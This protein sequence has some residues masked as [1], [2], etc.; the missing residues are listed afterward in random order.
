MLIE[1][2]NSKCVQDHISTSRNKLDFKKLIK[3][4]QIKTPKFEVIY[5]KSDLNNLDIY[6][7]CVV[8][9]IDGFSSNGVEVVKDKKRLQKAIN[10]VFVQNS[11]KSVLYGDQSEG[12]IIEEYIDGK[13]YSVDIIWNNS[14]A[15]DTIICSRI[16]NDLVHCPDYLYFI[17]P[18]IDKD[19]ELLLIENAIN[20][21]KAYNIIHGSTHTE[22][23]VKNN[24]AYVIDNA[25]R[26]GG[27][28]IIYYMFDKFYKTNVLENFCKSMCEIKS[29]K[30]V[31]KNTNG[32]EYPFL[33][34][35]TNRKKGKFLKLDFDFSHPNLTITEIIKPTKRGDKI[36]DPKMMIIYMFYIFGYAKAN[37]FQEFTNQIKLLDKEIKIQYY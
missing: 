19:L 24:I 16:Q 30:T 28:G 33:M 6:L 27:G 5:N 18:K 26:P 9:P 22:F 23:K 11:L 14:V 25:V 35:Y 20:I 13:E 2:I 37:S 4:S 8:K 32:K 21:G 36:P 31:I 1:L 12:C 7:P 10:S 17:D 29:T 3:K 34:F 15:V